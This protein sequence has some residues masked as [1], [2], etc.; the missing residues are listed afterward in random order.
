MI[1]SCGLIN[2][3]A[4]YV[5]SGLTQT[6]PVDFNS[7]EY[8]RPDFETIHA[9]FDTFLADLKAGKNAFTLQMSLSETYTLFNEAQSQYAIAQIVYYNNV[10][11]E[12]AKTE[13]EYCAEEFAKLQ[14]KLT[15]VYAA[16]VDYGYADAFLTGWT[17]Q[18]FENLSV[19]KELYDDEYIEIQAEISK[20]ETEYLDLQNNIKLTHNNQQY[21][22]DE[23][24][25]LFNE[26]AIN[27]ETRQKLVLEYYEKLADESTPIYIK[28]IKANNRIAEKAGFES[29]REYADRFEY[30]RDYSLDDLEQLYQLVKT[31]V[32]ALY[33]QAASLINPDVISS[34]YQKPISL[35][36]YN[37][38]FNT[39]F[40]SISVKM[41][42]AYQFMQRYNLSSIGN[43]S[44]MQ[45]AGFT[46]YLPSYEMP[47]I[48]LYTRGTVDDVSSFVHEFGHFFAFYQNAFET[49]SIIDVSEIHSQANELLFLKYY[50]LTAEE[51]VNLALYKLSEMYQTVIEGCV[52]DEFQHYVH[53]NIDRLI[54]PDDFNEAFESIASEYSYGMFYQGISYDTLWAAITHNFVAPFYYI[55]YAV[56]ALPALEIYQISLENPTQAIQIYLNVLDETGYR[57]YQTVL[58]DNSLHTP[59]EAKTYQQLS[60]LPNLILAQKSALTVQNTLPKPYH[61]LGLAA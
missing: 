49:D 42:E 26:G 28:L 61:F 30:S 17:E 6:G 59:F 4:N 5:V 36:D 18:D 60:E 23:I 35:S 53:E 46:T 2:I 15:E 39:Y 48:Y 11:D 20:L 33:T 24:V 56:S 51:R 27:A 7:I 45:Q 14:V 29:Y 38:I 10:N 32:P 3:I 34:V 43:A 21:T 16:I 41:K 47:F 44:G 22:I 50:N 13:S 54:T 25:T 12:T 19:Q 58:K 8:T 40:G 9:G 31:N 1:T 55:S 52:M 57:S 37:A